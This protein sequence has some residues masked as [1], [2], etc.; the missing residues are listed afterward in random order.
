MSR[1][2]RSMNNKYRI[3][4]VSRLTGISA[5]TLRIWE[6]RYQLVVPQRTEKGGR[7][8]SQDDVTRLTMIKTLVD[9]GHA[10]STVAPLQTR[11]LSQRLSQIRPANLPE[12]GSGQYDVCLVGKAITVRANNC[13][14]LPEGLEL[15]GTYTDLDA[16]IEDET[17]CDTLIVEYPFLDRTTVRQLQD[18]ALDNRCGQIIVVYAFSPSNIL[19]Q[20]SRLQISAERAPISIDHLWQL[21]VGRMPQRQA[22]SLAEFQPGKIAADPIPN[23][24]FQ[25]TQLAKYSQMTSA[26]KCECPNHMSSIIETLVAFEQYSAQCENEGAKDAALHAYL[27]VMTAKARWLMEVALE[28]LLETEGMA[29]NDR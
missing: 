8:Y 16:F 28:K 6:R 13:D 22:W 21:C 2:T 15:A 17:S 1:T 5:D 11:E 10:I 14:G 29:V 19:R 4:A 9:N 25:A 24:L 12:L 7:L 20:L 18:S 23:R 3:G 27:H 26:L